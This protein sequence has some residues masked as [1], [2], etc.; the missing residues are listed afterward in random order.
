MASCAT[1]ATAP[2]VNSTWPTDGIEIERRSARSARR[3]AMKAAAYN[4]GGT[5]TIS[6]SCTA[7]IVA[8][9]CAVGSGR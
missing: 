9:G 8:S 5:G 6:N 3:S 4:K 7:R 1:L 2:I